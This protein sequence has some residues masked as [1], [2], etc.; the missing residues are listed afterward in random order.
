[1]EAANLTAWLNGIPIQGH[2]WTIEEISALIY[3]V[4]LDRIVGLAEGTGR[5]RPPAD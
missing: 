3:L 1:V 2:E 4:E 5:S